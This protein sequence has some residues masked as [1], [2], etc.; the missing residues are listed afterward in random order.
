MPNALT[1]TSHN[2]LN[3]Y[4][5]ADP[6]AG[7][8]GD[9]GAS[10]RQSYVTFNGKLGRWYKG[11][12][13]TEFQSGTQAA[14]DPLNIFRGW[15]CWKE[16]QMMEEANYN[17]VDLP[18]GKLPSV[19]QLQ[20]ADHGPYAPPK[21]GDSRGDGYREQ[22]GVRG[23]FLDGN[24]AFE[25]KTSTKSAMLAIANFIKNYGAQRMSH[26]PGSWPV[27]QLG[28]VTFK[29][30][31]DTQFAP[32]LRIVGWLSPEQVAGLQPQGDGGNP[33]DY[34]DQDGGFPG[35]QPSQSSGIGADAYDDEI[36][37]DGGQQQAQP[38]QQQRPVA[39]PPRTGA[40]PPRPGAPRPR[41]F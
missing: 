27:V 15:I 38:V 4:A 10:R 30:N 9:M 40:A 17:I 11:K 37:F 41:S 29:V 3:A 13:N 36:P 21:P 22:S 5:G 16:K 2:A 20:L 24:E 33:A 18:G 35:D 23:V 14:L 19:E 25:Y 6:F 32:E 39:P 34:G 31:G 7:A 8:A 1:S 28:S 26:Q 12:D